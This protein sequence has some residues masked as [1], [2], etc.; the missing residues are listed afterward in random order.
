MTAVFV[1]EDDEITR[2]SL[3]ER[4]AAVP[5]LRIG[6][7]VG[8]CQEIRAALALR[9]P[10]VLLIDLGLPDGNGTEIIAEA[11]K[12]YP[13]LD[14]LVITVF[15]DEPHVVSA[16]RAGAKGYLLKDDSTHEIGAAIH[17]LLQGGSPIT[18]IIARHLIQYFRPPGD[19]PAADPQVHLSERELEVLSLAAKGFSYPEIAQMLN[20]TANTVGSYT[21]RIYE[22]LAVRSRTEAIYE[23]SRLGLIDESRHNR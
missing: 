22:K 13:G 1:V 21:K 3:C 17:E 2:R 7:A 4:I 23:A 12:R 11:V 19:T 8:T 18:P 20:L 15:G 10:D 6:V 9:R 5:S 14:I 16:L